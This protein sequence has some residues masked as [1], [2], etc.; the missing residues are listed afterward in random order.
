MAVVSLARATN[1]NG[2]ASAASDIAL[3]AQA[4][5]AQALGLPG[6]SPETVLVARRKDLVAHR[7]TTAGVP[8]PKTM[9]VKEGSPD[10]IGGYPLVVK[11][12]QG[13]GGR[14][15]TIV[16]QAADHL[17][18]ID[19]ALEYGPAL[20][21]TFVDGLPVGVEA[22]VVEG[23]VRR[24]FVFEDQMGATFPSPLGHA[25]PTAFSAAELVRIERVVQD[26]VNALQ[27][28]DGGV[29][30]DLRWTGEGPVVLEVNPRAGGA[31]LSPLVR[32]A[33]GV[34]LCAATVCVA[35]GRDPSPHL[36]L[37]RDQA[38][39]TRLF[40][41]KGRGPIRA[42]SSTAIDDIKRRFADPR[43]IE[44]QCN[45]REGHP[46]TT[47]IDHWSIL[48]HCL[49]TADTRDEAIALATEIDDDVRA[50][51]EVLP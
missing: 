28:A 29:N 42:T 45:L 8:T 23:V 48:G 38:A 14:G 37:T 16:R 24:C 32:E 5:V 2:V 1:C 46:A 44:G 13:A 20:Y 41:R 35:L 22:F 6:P 19:R 40:V 49:V 26:V 34:D 47:A 31:L 43:V 9:A 50:A 21:Q 30:L 17:D 33:Y 36:T 7:L 27:L 51:F 39:A 15:V 12:S 18:A 10:A 4:A 3:P 25:T 11:P